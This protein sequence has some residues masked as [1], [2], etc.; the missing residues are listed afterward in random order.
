MN[1][2]RKTSGVCVCRVPISECAVPMTGRD[3]DTLA[4]LAE[5]GIGVGPNHLGELSILV[6]A[7]Q[8]LWDEAAEQAAASVAEQASIRAQVHT[9]D[10]ERA[11]IAQ[12]VMSSAVRGCD[13]TP[14]AMAAARVATAN[15]VEEFDQT[16]PKRVRSM[17]NALPTAITIAM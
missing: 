2:S 13:G 6:S 12:E 8:E 14:R 9:A 15:A 7:A 11:R 17:L 10:N 1:S 3:A 4:Y 16:L 5:R